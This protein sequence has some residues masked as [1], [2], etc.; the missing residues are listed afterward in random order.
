MGEVTKQFDLVSN[1]S[2][3]FAFKI[4]GKTVVCSEYLLPGLIILRLQPGHDDK[5]EQ[6][7]IL[8]GENQ[9]F[10]KKQVVILPSWVEVL[11]PIPSVPGAFKEECPQCGGT[12]RSLGP[13]EFICLNCGYK[14]TRTLLHLNRV[15]GRGGITPL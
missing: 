3:N 15:V 4:D 14:G 6:V 13:D 12:A 1:E 7:K 8:L 9:D 10:S 5:I 11:K 2:K